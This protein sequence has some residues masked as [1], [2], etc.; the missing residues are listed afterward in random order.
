M[1]IR[2]SLNQAASEGSHIQRQLSIRVDATNLRRH[3]IRP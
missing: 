1:L 3:T 2:S